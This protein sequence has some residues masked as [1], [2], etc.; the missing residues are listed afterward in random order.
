MSNRENVAAG[1]LLKSMGENPRRLVPGSL[2]IRGRSVDW[3]E[4]CN[5]KCTCLHSRCSNAS[6]DALDAYFGALEPDAKA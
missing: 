4:T 5:N 1:I 3:T 6:M 2:G